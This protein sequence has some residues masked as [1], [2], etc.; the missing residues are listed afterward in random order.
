MLSGRTD[1]FGVHSRSES[2]GRSDSKEDRW[3]V[4]MLRDSARL[5]ATQ[6]QVA[7]SSTIRR[8]LPVGLAEFLCVDL[9]DNLRFHALAEG[10]RYSRK[11]NIPLGFSISAGR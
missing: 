4:I 1:R 2:A 6:A 10:D 7:A 11:G 8:R 3:P 9:I 5:D